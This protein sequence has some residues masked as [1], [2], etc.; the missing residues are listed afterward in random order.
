M[1]NIKPFLA[2]CAAFTIL[3]ATSVTAAAEYK[4]PAE[5]A[6]GLTGQ[7]VEEIIIERLETGKSFGAIADA[8]GKLE[9]FQETVL[10][11][12]YPVL[13]CHGGGHHGGARRYY[14]HAGH[15]YCGANGY[16]Y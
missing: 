15:S 12:E 13:G 3:A 7:T 6:A 11:T 2:A 1:K 10:S 8:A 9:E 4:T 5:A 14:S 16:C